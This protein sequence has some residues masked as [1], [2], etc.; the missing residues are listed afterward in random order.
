M[1]ILFLT[2]YLPYP[3]NKGTA[4]RNLH[5]LRGAAQGHQVYLL[6]FGLETDEEAIQVLQQDLAGLEVVP[7]PRRSFLQRLAELPS[8]LPDL[9]SRLHSPVFWL[10]LEKTL[11]TMDFDLLQVEGLEMAPYALE[12]CRRRGTSKKPLVLFDAHNAEY[13]LQRGAFRTDL[14]TPRRWP[15]AAYS[16]IQWRKLLRYEREVCRRADGVLAV[17]SADAAALGTLEPSL[18]PKI[19]PNGVDTSF[20]TYR[21][22][23]SRRNDDG[24]TLVFTGT[25]DYR[26]NV[27]AAVWLC[28]RILPLIGRKHPSLRLFLVG[29]DPAPAVRWLAGPGITVTGP[30]E[31]VRPYLYQADVF[32]APLRMGSGTRLKIL[33][34][35]ACGLPVV[36]TTLGIE[37]IAATPGEEVLSA[38]TPADFAA[39]VL[40]LLGDRTKAQKLATRARLLVEH[41]YDWKAILPGLEEAYRHLANW[42]TVSHQ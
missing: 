7:P 3:L 32:V 6:T 30:V 39:R 18:R 23:A 36:S 14:T 17:S 28:R 8:P 20:F 5:L 22:L 16:L 33:E 11:A 1:R 25:L 13:A 4:L 2:P 24:P 27:D 19:L 34:A 37:G 9:A 26:P 38:D 41:R 21:S 29:R 10:R 40:E 12:V 31:D 42:G 35:M 15:S